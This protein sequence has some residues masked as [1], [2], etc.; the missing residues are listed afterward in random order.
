[1]ERTFGLGVRDVDCAFKL[2]RR[3]VVAQLD[4]TSEGATISTELL[5]KA[6]A[7]GA[8]IQQLGIH[9]QPRVAGRQ[10]GARP[11]VV[12]RAFRELTILRRTLA[13]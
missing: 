6:L 9:H 1:M 11:R 12:V 8:R 5:V 2:M 13:G 7:R 3:D 4:L 10:S